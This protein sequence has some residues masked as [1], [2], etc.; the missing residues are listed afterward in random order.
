MAAPRDSMILFRGDMHWDYIVI[1]VFLG[2]VAPIL[3]YFRVRRLMQ[4][5]FTTSLERLAL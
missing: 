1:L 5:P 4:V 3:G 2:V